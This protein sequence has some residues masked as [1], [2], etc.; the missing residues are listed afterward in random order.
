MPHYLFLA[1]VDMDATILDTSDISTIR[2]AGL[3]T[4]W[5]PHEI[6]H[7]LSR[8]FAKGSVEVIAMGASEGLLRLAEAVDPV[9]AERVVLAH[10]A[11][12]RAS[13][14]HSDAR[15][16]AV[17]FRHLRFATGVASGATDDFVRLRAAAVTMARRKQAGQATVPRFSLPPASLGPCDRQGT[18][19]ASAMRSIREQSEAPLSDSLYDRHIFGRRMR[20][21]F[22]RRELSFG[23]GLQPND[24]RFLVEALGYTDDFEEIV[25]TGTLRDD[26]RSTLPVSV[27]GKLAYIYMDGNRFGQRAQRAA[28]R[29]EAAYRDFSAKTEQR[30]RNLLAA[31]LQHVGEADAEDW[32]AGMQRWHRAERALGEPADRLRFE[33][34]LW[35]GEEMCFVVPGWAALDVA[36]LLQ[37]HLADASAWDLGDGGPPLTHGMGLLICQHKTPVRL[38]RGLAAR[39][40]ED[41][42][43]HNRDGNALQIMVLESVDIPPEGPFEMRGRLLGLPKERVAAEMT[44]DGR[45]LGELLAH[46]RRLKTG[47]EAGGRAVPRSQLYHFLRQLVMLRRAEADE[48]DWLAAFSTVLERYVLDRER[49][50]APAAE[51]LLAP[52]PGSDPLGRLWQL[53][54]L[55]D[56]VDPL[57]LERSTQDAVA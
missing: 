32:R 39:L 19:P 37:A 57:M 53:T 6:A 45:G 48:A 52:F 18:L 13:S 14:L 25:E 41:A 35:G 36:A 21:A 4:L 33:T 43:N 2:G 54:Q 8:Q 40:N 1:G 27:R 17:P 20:Q 56:Y 16:P 42:K 10:L 28:E 29:G 49:L 51:W 44:F 34:L 47:G 11:Q 9:S 46:M 55:W 31:V 15:A 12:N 22:Y 26:L 50:G 7:I 38:A 30:R 23:T 3:A 5:A 24:V